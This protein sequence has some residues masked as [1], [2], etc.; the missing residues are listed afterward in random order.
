[1][2]SIF[3]EAAY[4]EV[5]QRLNTLTDNSENL[6]GKMTVAQM[7]AHCQLALEMPLGY[8]TMKR[9]NALVRMIFKAFKK[10]MYNDKPWRKNS[11]TA[12]EFIIKDERDFT[13]EK[14]KLKV[15]IEEF[16]SKRDGFQE[17]DNPVFGRFTQ[18]QLGMMQ[19]KHLD[20]HLKQF[21]A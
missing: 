13:L 2:N 9:P 21:N 3:N 8:K 19:Y 1:M 5:L 14:D 6:W 7:C 12:S 17:F 11:P 15:L 20:H 10:S 18:E 4:Q 16:Y